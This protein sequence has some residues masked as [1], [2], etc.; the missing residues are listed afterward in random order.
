MTYVVC[1]RL[2][3]PE[4]N[5]HCEFDG[6]LDL[7]GGYWTCPGCHVRRRHWPLCAE[8]GRSIIFGSHVCFAEP[9]DAERA[10]DG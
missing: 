3:D 9:V 1:N 2:L 7:D 5:Q 6:H 4:T 10:S 8:C